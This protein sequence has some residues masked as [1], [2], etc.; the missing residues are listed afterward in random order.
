M[1]LQHLIYEP[2]TQE[3]EP[4]GCWA[5]S[6]SWFAKAVKNQKLTIYQIAE[7]YRALMATPPE[8]K[9]IGGMG[10]E[11]RR[12]IFSDFR[13]R[14]YQTGVPKAELNES[15]IDSYLSTSPTFICYKDPALSGSHMNI[16]VAR[17]P[18]CNTYWVMDPNCKIFEPRALSYYRL[19]SDRFHIASLKDGYNM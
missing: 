1:G 13:W 15:F 4:M 18:F 2:V 5:C 3:E 11:G 17:V 6:L 19:K 14:L 7:M 9:K 10:D 16:I 8:G 12:R